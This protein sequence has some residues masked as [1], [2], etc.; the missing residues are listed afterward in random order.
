MDQNHHIPHV[1]N[2]SLIKNR[3]DKFAILQGIKMIDLSIY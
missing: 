1:E 3:Y 2:E